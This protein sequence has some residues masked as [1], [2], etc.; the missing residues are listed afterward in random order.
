MLVVLT[1]CLLQVFGGMTAAALTAW[2]A[3]HLFKW[4]RLP[5]FGPWLVLASLFIIPGAARRP[6]VQMVILFLGIGA[7]ALLPV[8]RAWR[9]QDRLRRM[10]KQLATDDI[11]K[12][13]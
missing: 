7:L 11:N 2:A 9:D 4:V 3:W 6:F 12:R 13:L 1:N 8:G 5:E 10:L